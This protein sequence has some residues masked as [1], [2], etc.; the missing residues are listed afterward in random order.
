MIYK[1][2]EE[3]A[4]FQVTRPG[5]FEYQTFKHGEVYENIPQEEKDRF[6]QIIEGGE[7]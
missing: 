5:E 4:D 2:K 7:I 1:L 6:E 3:A